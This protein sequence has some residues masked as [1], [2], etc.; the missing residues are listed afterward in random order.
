M[1]PRFVSNIVSWRSVAVLGLLA[2]IL[3]VVNMF[4]SWQLRLRD[5]ESAFATSS[6]SIVASRVIDPSYAGRSSASLRAASGSGTAYLRNRD[7]HLGPKI[8]DDHS[9]VLTRI[10]H[11]SVLDSSGE[12]RV[13]MG[14]MRGLGGAQGDGPYDKADMMEGEVESYSSSELTLVTQCSF[15][16][17]HKLPRLTNNWQGPISIAVFAMSGEVQA[18]V[19]TFHLLRRCH[20]GIYNNVTFSLVFPLNSP[21]SPHITPTADTTPCD[22]IFEQQIQTNYEFGGIHYPNNLLRNIARKATNT[23]LILVLDI[24]MIPSHGL[25]TYFMK[26]ASDNNIFKEHL[27]EEKTAWVLPAFEIQNGNEFPKTKKDLLSLKEKE[28]VRPFYSELCFKCQKYTDYPSWEKKQN[29]DMEKVSPLYEVLWQDPWEPF[30]IAR[31]GIPLYDERFRQYGFNRISQVCELHI[32]GF[33]FLVLDSGFVL[34]EGFKTANGFHKAKDMQQEA[35]RML[36]RQFKQDLKEKY[37]DSS[38]RCY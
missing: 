12:F 26:Y 38:R 25:H 21:T 17:L 1:F 11:W 5:Q 15:G 7:F 24:D 3:Q 20:S 19:Q 36:F 2:A 14:V 23:E 27:S 28:L 6:A 8:S 33:R 37:K 18:V 35:N 9:A 10:A 32:A 22:Q 13:A 4:L 30:Y 29:I 16:H 34:H 31:N